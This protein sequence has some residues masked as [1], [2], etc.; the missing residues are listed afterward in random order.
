MKIA[1]ISLF[2]E[3]LESFAALGVTGKATGKASEG[4]VEV[5]AFN[6]RDHAGDTHA[7]IDDRPYGGGPGMVMKCD[8]LLAALNEA[9]AWADNARVIYLSP[10]GRSL[11]QKC[12]QQ[13]ADSGSNLVLIAGRYEGLD[14]RFIE[15]EVD[16]QISVGDFV[17]SGGELPALLLLDGLLRL[18]PGVLGHQQSAQQ[19]S[20][21]EGLLD[22]P[23]FT[24]PEAWCEQAVPSVLLSGDHGAIEKWRQGQALSQTRRTRPDLVIEHWFNTRRGAKDN[25]RKS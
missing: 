1:L 17:V 14:Q 7:T 24:R 19:D 10:Q 23:H 11:Q 9:R 6:P 2:P 15:R 4:G 8:T 5:R 21:S 18:V 3:V 25:G 13:M 16:E 20:F 12:L 22:W